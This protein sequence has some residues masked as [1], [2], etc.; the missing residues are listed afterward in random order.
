M[1]IPPEPAL[2]ALSLH[3]LI[4]RDDVLHIAGEQV[5]IVRQPVC[6]RW[7]V[8]EHELVRAVDAG[9]AGLAAGAEC[10][11]TLPVVEH[12]RFRR[13]KRWTSRDC[14]VAFALADASL[15]VRHGS[16]ALAGSGPW[17]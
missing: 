1:A 15:R 16:T 14:F 2:D 10:P 6:E 9:L 8:V 13:R 3:R 17:P 11:I 12:V 7:A 4:A 5:T